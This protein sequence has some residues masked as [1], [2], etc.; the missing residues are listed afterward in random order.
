M[1]KYNISKELLRLSQAFLVL[2]NKNCTC[3]FDNIGILYSISY[4]I[5][6]FMFN[7]KYIIH[8]EG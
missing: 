3:P 4:I 8:T 5:F 2:F 7:V 6:Y 1:L